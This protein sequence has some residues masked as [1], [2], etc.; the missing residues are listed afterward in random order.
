MEKRTHK[1]TSINVQ[2][3]ILYENTMY[4]G[5]AINFSAN[6]MYIN[7]EDCPPVK[8]EFNVF[9]NLQDQFMGVPV[10]VRRLVET[11]D[12]SK[13]GMGIIIQ[14]PNQDYIHFLDNVQNTKCS[15]CMNM[16]SCLLLNSD[17]GYSDSLFNNSCEHFAQNTV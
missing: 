4:Q 2:T 1:R 11:H 9:F 14:N 5:T 3:N 8:S 16:T 12:L 7:S 17:S 10:E 15:K 6:G 13:K